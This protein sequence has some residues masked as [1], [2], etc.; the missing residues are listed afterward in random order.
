MCL[1]IPCLW[2]NDPLLSSAFLLAKLIFITIRQRNE[3]TKLHI[4]WLM[5]NQQ[6]LYCGPL[7]PYYSYHWFWQLFSLQKKILDLNLEEIQCHINVI[8]Y[9]KT[10]NNFHLSELFWKLFCFSWLFLK[11]SCFSTVVFTFTKRIISAQTHTLTQTYPP[12]RMGFNMYLFLYASYN[13]I[14]WDFVCV[15]FFINLPFHFMTRRL[16]GFSS[17][18]TNFVFPL[19]PLL[20]LSGYGSGIIDQWT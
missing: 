10:K 4:N 17:M 14:C 6:P 7:H 13:Y 18:T 12:R 16:F 11:I 19:A 9:M 1:A 2:P 15:F 20:Q 5:R 3:T 8:F